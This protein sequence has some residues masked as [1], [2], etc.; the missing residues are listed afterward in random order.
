MWV[1]PKLN[2]V[3]MVRGCLA[4]MSQFVAKKFGAQPTAGIDRGMPKLTPDHEA[5]FECKG[6][7]SYMDYVLRKCAWHPC[8]CRCS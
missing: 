3:V 8:N 2:F 5:T 1:L 6:H 7:M 4:F